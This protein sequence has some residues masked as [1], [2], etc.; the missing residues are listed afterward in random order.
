MLNSKQD[1]IDCMLKMADPLIPYLSEK[2]A[3]LNLGDTGVYYKPPCQWRE[4][5]GFCGDL[6]RCLQGTQKRKMAGDFQVCAYRRHEPR[7]RGI[8]GHIQR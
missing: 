7:E 5:H 6:F 3:R 4:S 1:F 2:K 8:L